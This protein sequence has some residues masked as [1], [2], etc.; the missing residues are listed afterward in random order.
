MVKLNS[1]DQARSLAGTLPAVAVERMMQFEGDD[2]GYDH[3]DH[4]YILVLEKGDDL[5]RDFPM[6]GECGLLGHLAQEGFPSF[7]YVVSVRE[8]GRRIFEATIPLA[9]DAMLVLIVPEEPWVDSRL[10][11]VLDAEGR[12]TA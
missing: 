11:R 3:E 7:E 1:A 6:L 10:L 8:N 5:R 4:G 9:G 12:E 2:G